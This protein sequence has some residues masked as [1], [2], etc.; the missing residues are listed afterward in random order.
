M[1]MRVYLSGNA[2]KSL[3]LLRFVSGYVYFRKHEA[4]ST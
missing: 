3:S 1:D 4:T 2:K